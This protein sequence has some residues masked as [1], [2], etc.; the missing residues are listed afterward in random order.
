MHID[1]EFV[2]IKIAELDEA[3]NNL[4][5]KKDDLEEAR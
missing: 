2:G 3:V 5:L 1:H 4:T